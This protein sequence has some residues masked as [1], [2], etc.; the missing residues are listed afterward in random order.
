MKGRKMSTSFIHTQRAGFLTLPILLGC[1]AAACSTTG[2]AVGELKEP[3]GKEEAVTL[4]WKSDAVAPDRGKISGVLPNGTHYAGRYFEVVHTASTDTYAP[5][6]EGW[7]PYW[8]EWRAPWYPEPLEAYDWP[9]FVRIY[10]GKVIAN[11]TSDDHA[12]RLRCRFNINDPRAG[13]V[14]GG[15]GDCQLSNGEEIAKVVVAAD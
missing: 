7:S 14:H 2:T 1:F 12:T 15:T 9:A 8:S 5:A 10:T 6:W 13:L 3:A 4:T 11:L